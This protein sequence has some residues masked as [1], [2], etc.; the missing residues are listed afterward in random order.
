MGKKDNSDILVMWMI[1]QDSP[2]AN[3]NANIIHVLK[4]ICLLELVGAN[5]IPTYLSGI[6]NSKYNSWFTCTVY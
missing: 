3:I 6:K 4:L 1:F 2:K 5:Y